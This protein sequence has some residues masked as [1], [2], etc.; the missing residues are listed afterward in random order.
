MAFWD[1]KLQPCILVA[2]IDCMTV[3]TLD[4]GWQRGVVNRSWVIIEYLPNIIITVV[5]LNVNLFYHFSIS[6]YPQSTQILDAKI[7]A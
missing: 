6:C 3:W 4:N 5:T 2:V 1:R 7:R